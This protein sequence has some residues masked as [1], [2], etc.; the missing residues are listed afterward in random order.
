M[1]IVLKA[2]YSMRI[3][4]VITIDQD[5]LHRVGRAGTAK[6]RS[7]ACQK[8]ELSGLRLRAGAECNGAFAFGTKALPALRLP[9]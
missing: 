2:V 1:G 7:S 9:T 6:N 5:S 3:M 8:A 4:T